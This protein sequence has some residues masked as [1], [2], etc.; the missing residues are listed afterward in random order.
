MTG[1]CGEDCPVPARH[2]KYR[3]QPPVIIY[4]LLS[5][6]H[7]IMLSCYHVI[8]WAAAQHFSSRVMS[9]R[10]PDSALWSPH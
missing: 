3:S 5:C 7:V 8:S 2:Y 1:E 9:N 10:R 6:Y 4:E